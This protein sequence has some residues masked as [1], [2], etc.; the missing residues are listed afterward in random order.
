MSTDYFC[1]KY[2]SLIIYTSN[3]VTLANMSFFRSAHCINQLLSLINTTSRR[4]EPLAVKNSI[5]PANQT[6]ASDFSQ[7]LTFL[8]ATLR[9]N[10]SKYM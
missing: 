5:K 8:Y 7:V 6:G 1:N 10:M 9:S 3:V 4:G 2:S